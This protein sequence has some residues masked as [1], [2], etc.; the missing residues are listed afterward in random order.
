[1]HELSIAQALIDIA[2]EAA[3]RDGARRVL[4]LTARIGVLSGIVKESLFFCFELAA[5]GTLCEGAAL[6][7]DD[8]QVT[9]MCPQCN[10]ARELLAASR[11][12]LLCP[13]CGGETPK[14]LHGQELELAS[15]E[16]EPGGSAL[17]D[18]EIIKDGKSYATADT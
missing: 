16:V 4:R 17:S 7:V 9:V 15:I 1:M 10:A 14:I 12:R 18:H 6:D 11:F 5:E 8:V 2:S 13:V 3:A